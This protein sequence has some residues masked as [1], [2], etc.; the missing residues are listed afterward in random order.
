MDALCD[1]H[2]QA[3]FAYESLYFAK[4]CPKCQAIRVIVYGKATE[5]GLAGLQEGNRS[6]IVAA[7]MCM[8][9]WQHESK[10]EKDGGGWW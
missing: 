4:P 10:N 6:T 2:G 1:R 8:H 9:I 7:P 3:M 5:S